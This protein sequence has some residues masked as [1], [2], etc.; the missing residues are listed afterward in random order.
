MNSI[1]PHELHEALWARNIA[2]AYYLNNPRVRLIDVGYKIKD[3]QYT[4]RAAIRLHLKNKPVEAA[5]EAFMTDNEDLVIDKSK[6]PFEVDLIQADYRLHWSWPPLHPE[7]SRSRAHDPL[8]GGISVS[9][10]WLYGFGTL[11]GIVQDGVTGDPMILSNWHVLAGSAYAPKGLII[12]QPGYGD[13]GNYSDTVAT[14]ERHAMDQD[15]D[16]AVARL[17]GDRGWINDQLEIGPVNGSQAPAV[18]MNVTKSGRM[19]SVTHG[20]ID[21]I[22]G[23]Y[24]IRYAGFTT[25]IRH[26]FRIVPRLAED[27]VSNKGDSGSWWLDEAGHNAVGLHFAGY[28]DPETALA[29][30]MP[31]VLAALKV[32]LPTAGPAAPTTVRR[33]AAEPVFA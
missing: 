20:F 1:E 18:G 17:T 23:E 2:A 16:A 30:S 7:N 28:D 8:R 12:Y 31:E 32:R 15:I 27:Q 9:S 26:V 5:F 29:I 14:L 19:T 10:E 24:P 33:P 25:S 11:G 4:G 3:G 21:G 22:L 13:G 6:I